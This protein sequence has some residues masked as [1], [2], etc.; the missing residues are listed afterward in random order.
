[1]QFE[2]SDSVSCELW[3][4]RFA[5]SVVVGCIA[6]FCLVWCSGSLVLLL[7]GAES[8]QDRNKTTVSGVCR[9]VSCIVHNEN[10]TS[11]DFDQYPSGCV[12]HEAWRREGLPVPPKSMVGGGWE[13]VF[14]HLRQVCIRR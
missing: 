1:M 5:L 3:S 4:L 11:V 12:S 9:I 10:L 13:A 6:C 8:L 2:R 14:K 7:L